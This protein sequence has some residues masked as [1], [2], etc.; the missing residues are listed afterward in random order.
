MQKSRI[1]ESDIKFKPK[2]RIAM[3]FLWENGG[4]GGEV[5]DFLKISFVFAY[6]GIRLMNKNLNYIL[7]NMRTL[8]AMKNEGGGITRATDTDR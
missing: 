5:M 8:V 4:G 1:L 3:S 6:H 7:Y 2:N